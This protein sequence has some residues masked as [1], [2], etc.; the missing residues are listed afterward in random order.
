METRACHALPVRVEPTVLLRSSVEI[1]EAE[2]N[3]RKATAGPQQSKKKAA[4]S[5]PVTKGKQVIREQNAPS[6]AGSLV[7]FLLLPA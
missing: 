3:C 1:K 5:Q 2:S 4:I 7:S 6:T